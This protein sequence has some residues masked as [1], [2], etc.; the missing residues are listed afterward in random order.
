MQFAVNYSPEAAAL[1]E[2]G[3]IQ[4]DLY[5]C[6]EWPDL[7]AEAQ[8]QRPVYIHFPLIAGRNQMDNIDWAF[9]DDVR[10]KTNTRYIN[11]H[12]GPHAEQAGIPMDSREPKHAE[13]FID[14]MLRDIEKV[15]ARYGAENII[16]ENLMCDPK[17]SVPR[18]ATE[19]E[20]ICRIVYETG[21]GLLLDLAHA[22]SAARSWGWDEREYISSLPL[23]QLRELH[24]TG[25][26]QQPSGLWLDHFQ[27]YDA[28]WKLVEWAFEQ[29]HAG[30]WARPRIVALEYGGI[31][32]L[33]E[34]RS[35]SD[36]IARDVPRLYNLVHQ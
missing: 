15:V 34:W 25:L 7:I 8:K 19:A 18:L 23:D 24:I 30:K 2:A 4:L 6:P 14:A 22:A 21:C 9:F 11:T 12:L 32:P 13:I 17:W 10:A 33:F 16:L 27:L 5:K 31:G 28:D 29:I 3:Q 26:E 35:K 1:L 36:V 20:T